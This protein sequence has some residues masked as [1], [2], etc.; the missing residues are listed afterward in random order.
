MS[1]VERGKVESLLTESNKFEHNSDF[2]Q[3]DVNQEFY[4][5]TQAIIDN[6]QSLLD[7]AQTHSIWQDFTADLDKILVAGLRLLDLINQFLRDNHNEGKVNLHAFT[8]TVR[9]DLR[10]PINAVIGY[11]EMLLEDLGE[12]DTE[13]EACEKLQKILAFARRLLTLF[14]DLSYLAKNSDKTPVRESE[15]IVP[16]S[17]SSISEEVLAPPIPEP[18]KPQY[19]WLEEISRNLQTPTQTV[20]QH[21]E[22]LLRH[23]APRERWAD[24]TNDLDKIL[25]AAVQLS[26]LIIKLFS[27]DSYQSGQ[28]DLDAFSA[29]VRHDLRTP[30]N[31][32]IGYSEMLLEDLSD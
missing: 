24:L 1:A 27:I 7:H 28:V 6:V 22:F 18:S 29:T 23:A 14:S 8:S 4:H 25:K 20:I 13:K 11:S 31:A 30:I 26:N 5:P 16:E 3:L 2:V 17:K 19:Q 21:M 15:E 9:H 32:I 10:T 12:Q